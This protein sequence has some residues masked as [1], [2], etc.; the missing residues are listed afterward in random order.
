MSL[1]L[2]QL[3]YAAWTYLKMADTDYIDYSYQ[4]YNTVV[5][6]WWKILLII[7]LADIEIQ[8]LANTDIWYFCFIKSI[9]LKILCTLVFF[10]ECKVCKAENQLKSYFWLTDQLVHH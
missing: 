1:N 10:Y 3:V 2:C 7:R 4:C 6:H 8:I 9:I 5:M